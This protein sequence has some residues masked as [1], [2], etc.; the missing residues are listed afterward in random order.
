MG[1]PT[2]SFLLLLALACIEAKWATPIE[3]TSYKDPARITKSMYTDSSAGMTH[4]A[5]CN[6]TDGSLYYTRLDESG[7]F[8]TGPNRITEVERCHQ[9][10]ITGP[11]DGERVII[12]FEARRTM[13]LEECSKTELGSCDDMFVIESVDGGNTWQKP[14]N[15][16]GK[17]GDVVRRRTFKLL[18]NWKSNYL[19]LMYGKFELHQAGVAVARY[20]LKRQAWDPEKIVLQKFT[21]LDNYYL[22][23]VNEKGD[24]TL[25]Y[26]YA[27]SFT[28]TL[29]SVISTDNGNTW[30]KS[31][32]LKDLC[33]GEKFALKHIISRGKY[34]VAG[35]TKMDKTYFSL[36]DDNG[37]TWTA[38][39]MF[40]AKDIEEITF[41]GKE[42]PFS[43][44]PMMLTLFRT[45]KYMNIS[46]GTLPITNELKF[47]NVPEAFYYAAYRMDLNCY[48]KAGELKLRYMYHVRTP[49]DGASKYTLY[50]IDNDNAEDNV[51]KDKKVDL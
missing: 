24:I 51:K 39:S 13:S 38:P 4:I 28:L 7:L 14:K 31:A 8:L 48:Y 1:R 19:W 27:T 29:Q 21:P 6:S 44:Q 10:E 25:Q 30:V 42:D 26:V 40:P 36:S 32:G 35:C 45:Q 34:L 33:K 16:G 46:V 12:A 18:L 49:V 22:S 9:V 5:Y 3:I 41:C 43:V 11:H 50:V 37:K 2:I 20:D 47:I 17:P 23:T 15:V